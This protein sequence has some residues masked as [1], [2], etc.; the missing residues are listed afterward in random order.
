MAESD[1]LKKDW[2]TTLISSSAILL[3]II[4]GVVAFIHSTVGRF[5]WPL[6]IV[7][8]F[9][10]SA[11]ALFLGTAI[12]AL[13]ALG[14]LILEVKSEEDCHRKE[15]QVS[16]WGT[17]ADRMFRAGLLMS[18]VVGIVGALLL[19]WHPSSSEQSWPSES[20]DSCHVERR[21]ECHYGS[22]SDNNR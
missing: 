3:P 1:S 6:L 9:A 8:I 22:R 11:V 10:L 16:N 18:I 15:G 7:D 13:D 21:I 19:N 5:W 14:A 2:L 4:V 17:N 20:N 12:Y